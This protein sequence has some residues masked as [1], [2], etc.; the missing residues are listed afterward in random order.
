[1]EE[2]KNIIQRDININGKESNWDTLDKLIE[3]LPDITSPAMMEICVN[4][5]NTNEGGK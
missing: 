3:E 4:E 2:F 1:M 5:N